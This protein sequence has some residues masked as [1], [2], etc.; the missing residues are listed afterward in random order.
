MEADVS[1]PPVMMFG[2]GPDSR[3]LPKGE[4]NR[5]VVCS[6]QWSRQG[7]TPANAAALYALGAQ[8]LCDYCTGITQQREMPSLVLQTLFH[9]QIN[10]DAGHTTSHSTS[11]PTRPFLFAILCHTAR[12]FTRVCVGAPCNG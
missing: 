4:V 3:P 5:N 2:D 9:I 6:L 7:Y 10:H 1:D 12:Y 8:I 11:S